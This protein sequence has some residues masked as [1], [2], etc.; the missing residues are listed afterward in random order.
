MK[1]SWIGFRRKIHTNLNHSKGT[2]DQNAT[3][4]LEARNPLVSCL[5]N[6]HNC[7]KLREVER[8]Q[9]S[10]NIQM[11]ESC[12]KIVG[13]FSESLNEESKNLRSICELQDGTD[14][15]E[16]ENGGHSCDKKM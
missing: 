16:P 14:E 8:M 15:K 7:T 12:C 9:A 3:E 1:I 11:H 6:I 4:Q 10:L 2:T 13:L 5:Q